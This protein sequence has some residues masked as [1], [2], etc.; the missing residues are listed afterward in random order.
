[1]KLDPLNESNIFEDYLKTDATRKD[2][3]YQLDQF[4]K[5]QEPLTKQQILKKAKPHLYKLLEKDIVA[6]KKKY[7]PNSIPTI[8]HT[9][10]W[11]FEII[12]DRNDVNW[13]KLQ[14]LFPTKVKKQ[15]SQA[16]PDNDI[17]EMLLI[18]G[19]N[20]HRALIHFF[21]MGC[22]IGAIPDIKIKHVSDMPLGCKSVLIYEGEQEEQL[23]FLTPEASRSLAAYLRTRKNKDPDSPLFATRNESKAMDRNLI[24]R[25]LLRIISQI[26][27]DSRKKEGFR[28]SIS[29]SHGFRK[30]FATKIKLRPDIS[31]STAERL[32][33]H[34]LAMDENYFSPNKQEELFENF[35]KAIPDLSL[36]V[37][38]KQEAEIRHLKSDQDEIEKIKDEQKGMKIIMEALTAEIVRQN[39]GMKKITFANGITITNVE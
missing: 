23:I 20:R 12:H 29:V 25:I 15:G 34:K 3:R 38:A 7:S 33:G 27:G 2:Y 13:K 16:W 4:W 36:D 5:R 14:K 19:S 9:I 21:C 17:R 30:R 32:I 31:H 35:C 26:P 11:Y 8:F 37:H 10:K 6:L 28:Y 39:P 18:A 22:R 1:M 24:H